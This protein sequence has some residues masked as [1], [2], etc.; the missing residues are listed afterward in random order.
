VDCV[1]RRASVIVSDHR[2]PRGHYIREALNHRGPSVAALAARRG[3]SVRFVSAL[4]RGDRKVTE[5]IARE[6]Q[7]SLGIPVHVWLNLE[8]LY[9]SPR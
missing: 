6:L 2:V 4:L 3:E 9:T 7:E 1:K 8:R 5:R